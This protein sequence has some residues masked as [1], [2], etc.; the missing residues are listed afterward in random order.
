MNDNLGILAIDEDINLDGY[1]V[2]Q[3]FDQNHKMGRE[4]VLLP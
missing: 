3:M 1:L 4:S 2:A